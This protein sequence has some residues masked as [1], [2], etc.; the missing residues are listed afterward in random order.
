MNAAVEQTNEL[1]KE[2]SIPTTAQDQKKDASADQ[3]PERTEKSAKSAR[4]IDG[5]DRRSD[6]AKKAAGADNDTD[7]LENRKTPKS[8]N[9]TAESKKKSQEIS[10]TDGIAVVPEKASNDK[11]RSSKS[12]RSN[13]KRDINENG[14]ATAAK[15]DVKSTVSMD[16]P[17]ERSS[18]LESSTKSLDTAN[19]PA[20]KTRPALRSAAVRPISARPSAPRRRDRNVRQILHTESF[21]QEP[22]S[23][24]NNKANKKNAIPEFDDADNIVITE[25]IQDNISLLDE[26]VANNEITTDIDG[27][28]GHLVQQILETQTAILKADAS[29][30]DPSAVNMGFRF[31]FCS[32]EYT[33]VF[34]I[35][36]HLQ[37]NDDSILSDRKSF[38][39]NT[40]ELRKMIQK[41]SLYITPLG[42]M[43]EYFQEDVDAMQIELL[44]WQKAGAAAQTDIKEEQ[45]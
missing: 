28:Q 40:T 43:M 6:V 38:T 14:M 16:Q 34:S 18:L 44:M 26:S 42:K 13:S 23:Q 45:R 20:S 10:G 8:T 12:R 22:N 9:D 17:G 36:R 41:L 5:A 32:V 15:P 25:T 7:E 29:K 30:N 3:K 24:Q 4:S 19:R 11:P 33:I 1:P 21:I 27:K 31:D 39:R 2:N 35:F 37:V